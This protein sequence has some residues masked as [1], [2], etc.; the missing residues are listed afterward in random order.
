MSRMRGLRRAV[1][2]AWA[3]RLHRVL[4]VGL[5]LL[6]VV[7][8][9]VRLDAPGDGSFL[10]FGS[11]T[12]RSGAVVVDVPAPSP[13]GLRPGDEVSAIA[14]VRLADGPG[15]LAEPALGDVVP[16]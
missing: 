15:G 11:S 16:Y 3:H 6:G 14:G 2:S 10:P 8:T 7:G 13:D 5:V 1:S 12:W 9:A 4:A